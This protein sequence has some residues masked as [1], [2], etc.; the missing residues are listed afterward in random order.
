[1][2]RDLCPPRLLNIPFTRDSRPKGG[3]ILAEALVLAGTTGD[4]DTGGTLNQPVRDMET[5]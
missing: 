1:M 3:F 5:L 4:N 2:L